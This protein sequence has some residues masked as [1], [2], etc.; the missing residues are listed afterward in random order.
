MLQAFQQGAAPC[1][2]RNGERHDHARER[3]V[4]AALEQTHPQ[5]DT[6]HQVRHHSCYTS[7]I[8]HDERDD[9]RQRGDEHR[10]RQLRGV[11]HGNDENGPDVIENRDRGQ[12]YPQR[13]RHT[14]AHDPQNGE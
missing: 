2:R 12:E 10:V 11:E 7:P 4:Y 1:L 3:R 14:A 8:H 13:Y 6:R 5:H 9:R